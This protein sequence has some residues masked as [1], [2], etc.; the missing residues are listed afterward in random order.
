MTVSTA[1]KI[2]MIGSVLVVD[3]QVALVRHMESFLKAEAIRPWE[4]RGHLRLIPLKSKRS[5][6][7]C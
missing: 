3:D 7:R 6:P 1:G 4:F 5:A 2:E